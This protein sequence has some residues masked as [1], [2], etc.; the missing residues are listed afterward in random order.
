MWE[1]L[2]RFFG[3]AETAQ[4]PQMVAQPIVLS[5]SEEERFAQAVYRLDA[6]KRYIE[7]T[8]KISIRKRREFLVETIN[9]ADMLFRAG[10]LDETQ[11]D[12]AIDVVMYAQTTAS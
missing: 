2:K 10:R 7:Q 9:H 6:I 3:K 4:A 5:P 11:H 12:A 1:P 8:P